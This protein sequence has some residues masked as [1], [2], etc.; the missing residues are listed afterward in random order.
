MV[1]V[2]NAFGIWRAARLTPPRDLI[3]WSLAIVCALG[4]LATLWVLA[5][6]GLGVLGLPRS[7]TNPSE[8]ESV[9]PW[10]EGRD[11]PAPA[12]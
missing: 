4:A 11:L 6:F 10:D 7:E 8:Q 3:E 5:V 1:L 9:E 12:N 2:R